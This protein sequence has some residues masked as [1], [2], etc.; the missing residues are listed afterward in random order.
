MNR[1]EL[2]DEY[3]LPFFD[4]KLQQS[5]KE[6]E[7]I[8][9]TFDYVQQDHI[10]APILS[11][12]SYCDAKKFK[13]HVLGLDNDKVGKEFENVF[14]NNFVSSSVIAKFPNGE[15]MIFGAVDSAFLE[16]VNNKYKSTI[17]MSQNSNGILDMDAEIPKPTI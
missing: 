3:L 12:M 5:K 14:K 11:F 6:K 8:N 7:L 9:N 15:E 10:D 4:K 13:K 16:S 17:V 1:Q 2:W